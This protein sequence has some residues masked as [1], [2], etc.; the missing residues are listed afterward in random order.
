MLLSGVFPVSYLSMLQ[1]PVLQVFQYLLCLLIG[2]GFAYTYRSPLFLLGD[3]GVNA[4]YWY[5][6]RQAFDRI[7]SLLVEI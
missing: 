4:E 2:R 3:G 5:F 1:K 6:F 7:E